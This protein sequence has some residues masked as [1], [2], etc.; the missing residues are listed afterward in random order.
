[1]TQQRAAT[2]RD[3][4]NPRS[5][6]AEVSGLEFLQGLASGRYPGAAMQATANIRLDEISQGRVTFAGHPVFAHAN[7]FGATHGG[8]YGVVL[9]SAMGCAVMSTLN[10]GTWYTTLDYHVNILR[11][12]P[13]G[14]EMVAEGLI[15]HSGRSTAVARGEI[16]GRADGR[17]YATGSTTCIVFPV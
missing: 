13:E 4:I 5:L 3:E 2:S 7:P 14:M 9:D 11:P 10:R 6:M 16:R 15:Q 12:L 1:M 8:W 17:L